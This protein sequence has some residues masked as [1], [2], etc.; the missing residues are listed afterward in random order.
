MNEKLYKLE[1]VTNASIREE[2]F[3]KLWNDP[4]VQ[5]VIKRAQEAYLPWREFKNKSWAPGDKENSATH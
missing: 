3:K 1:N 5:S 4:E 2:E